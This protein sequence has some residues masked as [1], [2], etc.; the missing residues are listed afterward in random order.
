MLLLFIL[1]LLFAHCDTTEPPGDTL[2][3]G[4]R[5][6]NWT[7]DTLKIPF[8]ILTS[9]WG[10]SPNDVWL[11]GPGGDLNKTIYHFNGTSWS[12]DGISR[13]IS[14][15]AVFGYSGSDVWIGGRDGKIWHYDNN[16]KEDTIFSIPGYSIIGIEYLWGDSPSSLIATGYADSL[17]KKNIGILLK[18][19]GSQWNHIDI[20]DVPYSLVK[21]QREKISKQ[22]YFV[23]G[24]KYEAFFDDT[25]IVFEFDGSNL[26]P[27]IRGSAV[28]FEKIGNEMIFVSDKSLYKYSGANLIKFKDITEFNFLGLVLGRNIKDIFLGMKDGIG[29]FNGNDIK[30]LIQFDNPQINLTGATIF[31]KD[32]IFLAYDFNNQVNLVFRGKVKN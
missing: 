27:V 8:T 19:N 21:I 30:Y 4:R 22:N 13:P 11:I 28:S 26:K 16:W 2:Q 24:F 12:N 1:I 20:P 18:Y 15:K 6:Y 29:H 31:E 17:G 7:V 25:L 10:S 14:P 32:V 23:L 9:I 3:P 5:D